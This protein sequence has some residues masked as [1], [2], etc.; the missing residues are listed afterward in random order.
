MIDLVYLN[1]AA[2]MDETDEWKRKNRVMSYF[3][4]IIENEI[5]HKALKYLEKKYIKNKVMG[6][7][8]NGLTFPSPHG[9]DVSKVLLD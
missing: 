3:C 4:G 2:I 8:F 5:T 7:S 6:W 9:F 1:N